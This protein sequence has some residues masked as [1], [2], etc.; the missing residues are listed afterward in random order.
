M[1]PV[2]HIL[3]DTVVPGRIFFS[4][5]MPFV[6]ILSEAALCSH[7]TRRREGERGEQAG[8]EGGDITTHW[9]GIRTERNFRH[10][11]D[12]SVTLTTHPCFYMFVFS[13]LDDVCCLLRYILYFSD[14]YIC[15]SCL[16][17]YLL[18]LYIYISRTL[19][20]LYDTHRFLHVSIV[21]APQHV[22]ARPGTCGNLTLPGD[23]PLNT[24]TFPV[25]SNG[26]WLTWHCP[27]VPTVCG[28]SLPQRWEWHRWVVV[29]KRGHTTYAPQYIHILTMSHLQ[30]RSLTPGTSDYHTYTH[31]HNVRYI[32][33]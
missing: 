24:T 33:R 18:D 31:T 13:A 28:A 4:R 22:P 19:S 14:L 21:L 15:S 32:H 10:P 2:L 20:H 16:Y 29:R 7:V 9:L 17:V 25:L 26:G 12:R 6:R 3:W 23:P 30:N 8:A 5:F 27:C 11:V 1:K